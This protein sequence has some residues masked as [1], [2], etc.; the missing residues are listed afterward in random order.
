MRREAAEVNVVIPAYEPGPYLR[1]A[2]Q[3]ICA[4][5]YPDWTAVVV[6]DG[7]NEDLGWV[8]SIDERI[9]IVRTP[10]QGVA[11]ARNRG[12]AE[13]AG[14]WIAFC[15]ADDLWSPHKLELQL[16]R[17]RERRADVVDCAFAIIE[18][19]G[20]IHHHSSDW[21]D[22]DAES[23][24]EAVLSGNHVGMSCVLARRSVFESVGDFDPQY[25]GV[26]DWD[27]WLRITMAGYAI[28]RQ[29]DE[30]ASWRMHPESMS[31]DH[32]AM[33][34]E[35]DRLMSHHARL[36]SERGDHRLVERARRTRREQRQRLSRQALTSAVTGARQR[37]IRRSVAHAA[38]A[39]RLAP[40]QSAAALL[41][42]RSG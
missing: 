4:Q 28:S 26:A 9:T 17:A 11:R 24:Y 2:L 3:S 16:L 1:E 42:F 19:T 38:A 29:P 40:A 33:A 22:I 6:D 35:I 8:G 18:P 37:E 15:D 25:S 7:S 41:G 31:T 10:N 39:F 27:M 23:G 36:A 12:I 21:R 34:A 20:V 5:T 13:T 30:L 14:T 32:T